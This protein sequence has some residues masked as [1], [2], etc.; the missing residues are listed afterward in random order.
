MLYVWHTAIKARSECIWPYPPIRLHYIT[1]VTARH[2]LSQI[3]PSLTA[4][5][6]VLDAFPSSATPV[7]ARSDCFTSSC[8]GQKKL[9]A[10]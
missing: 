4:T 5:A 6:I 8:E 1:D 7:Q 10:I 9:S 3:Y 2:V